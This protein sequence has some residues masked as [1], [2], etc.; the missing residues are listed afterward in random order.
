MA[1][2]EDGKY[3]KLT[4]ET[5][6]RLEE[7]FAMD[8]P[9]TEACLFANIT[10]PTYYAWIKKNPSLELRFNALRETPF[11]VARNTINK[12]IKE[13]PQYAFEYMKRKK[14]K[15]FGDAV[16]LTSDGEKIQPVLVKFLDGSTKDN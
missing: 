15:E 3:T 4:D 10:T 9:V 16:D 11:L 1:V 8:C 14:K 6:K 5:I 12:A 2:N 7:A 13:N